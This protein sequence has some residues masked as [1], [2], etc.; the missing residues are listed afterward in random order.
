MLCLISVNTTQ[1]AQRFVATFTGAQ[2]TPPSGSTGTGYGSVILSDDQTTITVNMGFAGLG[3]NATAGH[4]HTAPTAVAGPVTF[5]FAGVPAATGGVITQQTFAISPAQVVDLLAGNMYFNVHTGGFPGGEI[6]GQI[7][8]PTCVVGNT[9]EVE[10]TAGTMG[11]TNYTTLT[12]AF[13]AINAGTHQGAISIDVCGNT[14]EMTGTALLSASGGASSYTSINMSPVG[15][16]ART[17]TGATTTGNPMIDLS[18]AD[19]VTIDGLNTGGNSLTIANTTSPGTSGT[20]TIRFI[21]GA[22]SNTVTNCNLQGSNATSVATNGAVVFFSTDAVTANGNDN[23][24]ISNNNIGPAGANR[25]AKSILCNGSTTTTAIGNS[26]LVI[27][28]NNIFDYYGAA[29]TSTGVGVNGGCNTFSITNNRFYQTA[30]RTQTTAALHSAINMNSSTATSGVQGMTITGNTIGFASNTQTGTYTLTGAVASTFRGISFTGITGGVVSNINSNTIASISMTGVTSSG[31]SSGSPF[32]GIYIA[33]GLANTNS[34]TIGSQSATGSLTYSSNSASASDVMGTFNFSLDNWTVSSNNIGG[35]TA[36]NTTTG[37]ANV[38]GIRLNTSPTAT[39]TISSNLVGGTVADSLQSTAA[40]ATTGTQVAGIFVSTS[41]ATLTGNTIRNLTAPGG[42]GTTTAAS[43]AG[44]VFISAT[45]VNTA[46]QNTIF[47][48]SNTNPTLATIVTGIQFTGGTG[49]VVE[50][51]LIH[52]LTSATNSATAE[53]NG[54]RVAGGTTTYRNNMIA[55]GAGTA[56]AIGAVASTLS[57]TGINGIN[58]PL[59]TDNFFHNSVYIGGTATAGTGASYAFNST[60]TVNTRSFRDNI[61]FNARTNGGATGKHYAIKLNGGVPNPTGLTINNNLYF[62]NGSGAVFGFYNSLDVANIAAWKTAVGQDAGSFE[63]NPQY[64]DPTNATPDLHLHPTNP[65]VAEGNG[66]D[67]GVT[68]DFDGQTRASLTPVD[69]GADAGNFN[70]IDLAAPNITYTPLGNTSLTTNRIQTVTITD[71]TGVATGGLAP[72][73]YFNKNAGAYSSTAC[74]LTSGTVQNGTWDCT[75]NNTLIGGVVAT[76]VIRYFVV[77]QDT[78][79]NLGANPSGGFTGTNV[80]MVTTPPTTPNQ[81]TIVAAFTGSINV[82]TAETFTSLTNTGGIFEAINAGALTGDVTLNLTSDLASELG[83]VALN[84]WAEDGVG[85]YRMLIKPSGA[86]RMIVGSNIGALIRLNGA[87]RVTIDGSTAAT[88]APNVVGGNPAL[89]ELTIQNTNVGTSATVISVGSNGT[90]GAQNDTIRNV[91]VLGQD[92]TTTLLGISLGGATPGTVATGPNNNNRVENC[93]VKR[94]IFGI[95]SAGAS[96]ANPN[97]GTVITMN[98]TSAVAGDRIRRVG[99]VVFNENGVQ[100]TENSINGVSTNESADGI[101]IGVG[102]Q[103]IDNTNTTTGGISNAL[104]ARNKINGV[105]SLSAVGFSAAGITVAG[106]TGGANTIVNNMISGV[107][108]PATSPDIVA[109]IY[110]VGAVGSATRLY[111]NSISM[112]GDRGVVLTQTPSFGVAVTGTDP[113]VELKNNI[114][115]TTQIASGGGVDAKS[116]AIGM[117]TTTFVNL[118]SNYN[119]FWSTGANDGGFRS[120]SLSAALG[121]DYATLALWRTAVSD[122]A[123]SQEADP[124]YVDPTMDLHLTPLTSPMLSTGVTGFATVDLD[125]DTRDATPDI[126]ADEIIEPPFIGTIPAGSYSDITMSGAATMSGNVSLIGTLTLNG[127]LNTGGNTLTLGCNSTVSGAGTTNYVIGDLMR[128]VCGVGAKAFDVG[129]AN[130]YSPVSVNATAG[131]FPATFTVKATQG[132][133][134]NVNASTSIQRYWTLTNGGLTSANLTF[135]YLAGDVMGTEANYKLIR[136]SGGTPVAFPASTVD[137]MLHT[138]SLTGVTG[139]S[140]WTVGQ[141]SAPTAAPATISGRVTTTSG[142]PLAGVPMFLSGARSARAITDAN[143]NYRFA[144][145]DTDNFYT[146]TPAIVNYQFSPASRSFSLLAD[147]TDA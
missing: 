79:G 64:N 73:I 103:G 37:A 97:T 130:G 136:I 75:I 71:V 49:N 138:A 128:N 104:V 10:A 84:P 109:G 58:E 99:I 133:H 142:A 101:G 35:I 12:A 44:I 140:D 59:G 132:A 139:F 29:V 112:T 65:T 62:A 6:R 13:A 147:V 110:V 92:P 98:E 38:Y 28:N 48:L 96:V 77:A 86:P 94:S 145:I 34:N 61:F 134:P 42:T 82:G 116:Y 43:V 9:I 19:N 21:G 16:A 120:G 31:T 11:P 72:R 88:L 76:D 93:S 89:R 129:T 119:D 63:A 53:V 123:N 144:N 68:N 40:A 95:Y 125:N 25:P 2:E 23:N 141:P 83:T 36:A 87:D 117:V 91:N 3:T 102:T 122:D 113:T 118:D 45:P 115:Y 70:G 107:T 105:A 143:G 14:D 135:Q 74:S 69:I 32:M 78:V 18:G 46:S 4:I 51:N 17:I 85:G 81:Y 33:N 80:N 39:T 106:T 26:G 20:S 50:R 1:A 15:G 124:L 54:I 7:L 111:H 131:T 137:T 100:I 5:G 55:I 67:V 90:N 52:S 127:I 41:I 47:N 24:T 108:A 30:T 8:V 66:A 60:Q 22:T 114:F 27:N 146:V 126:G 121:T 57:T 56:N